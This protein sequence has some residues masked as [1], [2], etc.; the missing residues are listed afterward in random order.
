MILALMAFPS[1]ENTKSPRGLPHSLS[2]APSRF[3]TPTSTFSSNRP[4]KFASYDKYLYGG[5]LGVDWKLARD[6]SLETG[7]RFT[8]YFQNIEGKLSDPFIPLTAQDA[9]NTDDSLAGLCLRR[10]TLT[11]RFATLFPT[12]AITLARSISSNTFGLATPFGSWL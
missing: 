1:R 4:D 10:A 3:S 5:Q 12:S 2:A 8:Y 9:G 7:D 6:F 11:S